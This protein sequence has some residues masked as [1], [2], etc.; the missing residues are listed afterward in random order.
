M[1]RL[2]FYD[3]ATVLLLILASPALSAGLEPGDSIKVTLRG[4]G[5]GEQEKVNGEYKLGES[6]G[7]RLPML[8]APL[9]AKG[10]VRTT[11]FRS[12]PA[13]PSP[14]AGKAPKK[15]SNACWSKA[16]YTPIVSPIRGSSSSTPFAAKAACAAVLSSLIGGKVS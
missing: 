4:I 3:L 14:T 2:T 13:V 11:P 7:V 6:G 12:S 15:A 1:K 10:C 8:E 9:N 16:A 5:A